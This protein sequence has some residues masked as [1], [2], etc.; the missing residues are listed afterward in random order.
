LTLI[1]ATLLAAATEDEMPTYTEDLQLFRADRHKIRLEMLVGCWLMAREYMP[2]GN[3]M[4]KLTL[5]KACM[6]H[7]TRKD[8]VV[9]ITSLIGKN[10]TSTKNYEEIVPAT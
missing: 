9:K 2:L 6:K 4:E 7:I 3:Q 1:V 5:I 8:S 10:M